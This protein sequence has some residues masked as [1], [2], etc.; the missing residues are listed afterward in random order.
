M[1]EDG[2]IDF[3]GLKLPKDSDKKIAIIA[4]IVG[5]AAVFILHKS[6]TGS[7]SA[8]SG[9]TGSSSTASGTTEVVPVTGTTATG[10]TT[11]SAESQI[12]TLTNSITGLESTISS[13]AQAQANQSVINLGFSTNNNEQTELTN[14][15]SSSG[16]GAGGLSLFGITLGGTGSSSGSTGSKATSAINN[17]FTS[18][19]SLTNPTGSE[20][21]DVESWLTNIAGTSQERANQS[22]AASQSL[23]PYLNHKISPQPTSTGNNTELVQGPL[24]Q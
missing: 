24:A 18:T 12:Q 16:S 9:G 2:P 21:D 5:I 4:A 14:T 8:A 13:A 11:T 10:S 1:A 3:G 19:V 7:S 15:Q 20:L 22:I 6:M 17:Q 23:Y